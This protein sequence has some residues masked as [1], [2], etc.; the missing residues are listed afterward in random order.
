MP[1]PGRVPRGM[2]VLRCL[3]T[4]D[5]VCEM[6]QLCP[7][8]LVGQVCVLVEPPT[9]PSRKIW[10]SA[11]SPPPHHVYP[12]NSTNFRSP[13]IQAAGW[14]GQLGRDRT[15]CSLRNCTSWTGH[16]CFGGFP[17]GHR[18]GGR[19]RAQENQAGLELFQA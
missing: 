10:C 13:G 2:L 9:V 18:G 16:V 15:Q 5:P 3:L 12:H 1:G 14:G 19:Y 17:R 6:G 8:F 7:P 4:C 11:S